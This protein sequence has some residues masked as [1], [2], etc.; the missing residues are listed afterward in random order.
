[1]VV[2]SDSGSLLDDLFN[3]LNGGLEILVEL[4]LVV[5]VEGTTGVLGDDAT[6]ICPEDSSESKSGGHL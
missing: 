3:N 5:L 2:G 4:E 1:M 6:E